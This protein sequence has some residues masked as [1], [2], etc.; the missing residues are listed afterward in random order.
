MR[1]PVTLVLVVL[2]LVA[3]GCAGADGRRAQ[4]LLSQAQAAEGTIES[5]T[6]ELELDATFDGQQ[7]GMTMRGG[8]YVKGKRAGDMF[9]EATSSGAFA[10]FDFGVVAVGKRAHL[11]MNG[12]W[13]ELPRPASLRQETSSDLGSAALL[14]LARYV[15]KVNVTEHQFIDGEPT[16]IISGTVDTAGLVNA[17]AKLNGVA[18][19]AGA[20]APNVSDFTGK[21]GDTR[22]TI[23]ISEKTH[24]VRAAIVSLSAE[25]QGKKVDL[26]LVY[27]LRDVNGPVSFPRPR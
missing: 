7:V 15:K 25:A 4:E 13:R 2:A 27:R 1:G 21:L 18:A 17:M 26:Q 14:E 23:A 9:V 10:G 19:L 8:G 24:L 12:K 6:F 5:A 16:A 3:S 11:R 20:S 22:A